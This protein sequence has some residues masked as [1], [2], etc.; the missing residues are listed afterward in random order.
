MPKRNKIS[1]SN[2]KQK[3]AGAIC[4]TLSR[5]AELQNERAAVDT[6]HGVF[7]TELNAHP[8]FQPKRLTAWNTTK[9]LGAIR[10]Y[11]IT[12]LNN[13]GSSNTTR[14]CVHLILAMCCPQSCFG[15]VMVMFL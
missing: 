4:Q 11:K 9:P 2:D 1:Q 8:T 15:D 6:L 3:P 5:P 12:W 7:D 10:H 13:G 14:G